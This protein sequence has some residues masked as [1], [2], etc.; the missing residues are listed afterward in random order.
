VLVL[1]P[2]LAAVVR[3]VFERRDRGATIVELQAFLL[4][5]G[6][7]RSVAGVASMLRSRI[8]LG[9]IRFGELHNPSAHEPIIKDR[10]LFE[11]V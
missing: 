2:E 10:G 7:E 4:E 1:V 8:Y 5:R 11:P 6:I 9:E 3:E